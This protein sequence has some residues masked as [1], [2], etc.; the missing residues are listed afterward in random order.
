M[1]MYCQ[2]DCSSLLEFVTSTCFSWGI[3]KWFPIF[4]DILLPLLSIKKPISVVCPIWAISYSIFDFKIVGTESFNNS[5]QNLWVFVPF[6]KFRYSENALS[7][8]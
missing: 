2:S 7:F 4:I 1:F 8:S 3:M 6:L 5:P